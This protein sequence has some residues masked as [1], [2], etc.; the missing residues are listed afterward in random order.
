[1]TSSNLASDR[2]MSREFYIC[3]KYCTVDATRNEIG[4]KCNRY[5][6]SR[7]RRGLL[8]AP[9]HAT[10]PEKWPIRSTEI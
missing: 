4:P 1:M 7:T 5:T 10:R 2:Y 3:N 9:I 8:H 6:C